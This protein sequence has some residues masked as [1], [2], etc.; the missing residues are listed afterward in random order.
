VD[1][2]YPGVDYRG[3]KPEDKANFVSL[4]NDLRQAI[5]PNKELS[6]AVSAVQSVIDVGYDIAGICRLVHD[7]L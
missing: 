3:G 2:E 5:G 1:W 4:L 7:D 6:I